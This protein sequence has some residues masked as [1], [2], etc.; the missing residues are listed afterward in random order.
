MKKKLFTKLGIAALGLAMAVVTGA[1][2]QSAATETKAADTK[3]TFTL[4]D[5]GAAGHSDSNTALTTYSETVD[6]YTLNITNGSKMYPKSKD[7]KGNGCI[8]FGTSSAVGSMKFIAPQDINSVILEV[9]KYKSNATKISVNGTAYTLTKNSNDGAYDQITVDT[10]STKTVSFTTVSGGVRA[11]LNS[12]VFVKTTSEP[13]EPD[14]PV[15]PEPVK[16]TVSFHANGGEGTME[17]VDVQENTEFEI[18]GC[19]F[20]PPGGKEFDSWK[21][22]DITYNPGDSY[23]VVENIELVAQWKDVETPEPEQPS[24][25]VQWKKVD[26]ISTIKTTDIVVVTA[27][28]N[29][30]TWALTNN[31]GTSDAPTAAG[32]TVV[33]G[34]ITSEVG[35]EIKWNISYNNG[36]ITF[37]P[38]GDTLKW[39]Y[40]T[41]T[42]NGVR[43]GTNANKTF[44]IDSSSGYFK[45]TAT[46][47]Y[48]GVYNSQDWRCYDNTTGNTANQTFAIYKETIIKTET[49]SILK[50]ISLTNNNYRTSYL[51]VEEWD[52][53]SLTSTIIVN[54]IYDDGT[55]GEV[56]P[57]NF[58]WSY[59]PTRPTTET[60]SVTIT[61]KYKYDNQIT[62]SIKIDEIK[63]TTAPTYTKI[64]KTAEIKDG[65]RFIIASGTNALGSAEE[66]NKFRNKTD[67]ENAGDSFDIIINAKQATILTITKDI[68]NSNYYNIKDG[69]NYLGLNSNDNQL[70]TLDSYNADACQWNIKTNVDDLT[71]QHVKYTER[72][73]QYNEDYSRFACYKNTQKYP[74]LYEFTDDIP[75]S[76]PLKNI[77]ANDAT[78][79]EGSTII[80]T[81]KYEPVNATENI[82]ATISAEVA[83]LGV[84]SMNNG[85]F[86][87]EI[88]GG[89]IETNTTATLTF[90]NE[91]GNIS[92]TATLTIEEYTAT[93]D[94]VTSKTSIQNGSKVV[95][96]NVSETS[97]FTAKAS[98][99]ANNLPTV[100]T[101]FDNTN[102]TIAYNQDAQEFTVWCVDQENGYYVFSDGG[103][104]LTAEGAKVEDG[105]NK[106]YLKRTDELSEEC[107]FEL[108]ETDDGTGVTVKSVFAP[109]FSLAYNVTSEI[110]SLYTSTSKTIQKVS[111]YLSKEAVDTVQ[112][113]IDVFMHMKNIDIEDLGTGNCIKNKY[114]ESAMNAYNNDLTEDQRGEFLFIDDAF[115]R[116]NAWAIANN[117]EFAN[118]FSLVAKQTKVIDLFSNTNNNNLTV[119]IVTASITV[120]SAFCLYAFA[121]KT[122]R[123]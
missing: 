115:N 24:G 23:K 122:K 22:G 29:S 15:T 12:I 32:I 16:Y 51:D 30:T 33:N 91:A 21:I 111:L 41:S 46:N 74:S 119:I 77:T 60:S 63:V 84:V 92:G 25:T 40:C 54:G 38:N 76:V 52:N 67:V 117:Y 110:V 98:T 93:H 61:A 116:L 97:R 47:R 123:A 31:K 106:N 37:Y 99:G 83:T 89:S 118:D 19:G 7:A 70:H 20:T 50:S 49:E 27:T 108:I 85:T 71:I 58:E 69:D 2:I 39:L 10:S 6:G 34:E 112:G 42:N 113:F 94:L 65:G 57:S 11:M 64:T 96:G 102:K 5:D 95:L 103:Y 18:P 88:K 66:N 105:G 101:A 44:T 28:K 3:I 55:S 26:D 109:D 14:T 1:A 81:G 75:K 59:N 121:R 36:N 120:L 4:G 100:P 9:A 79:S 78:V 56:S 107:Y 43:V 68:N 82:V 8:K 86:E 53:P 48:L 72:Y 80:Y 90:S 87:L 13:E 62:D 35:D 114:F 45:H 17:T 104:F 73:I